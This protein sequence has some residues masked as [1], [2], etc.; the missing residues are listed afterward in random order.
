M[1]RALS[2]I[3]GAD[4]Q[5]AEHLAE[6]G[7]MVEQCLVSLVRQKQ[8]LR[9]EKAIQ[10]CMLSGGKRLRPVLTLVAAESLGVSVERALR[11]ACAIEMIHTASLVLDDL[12]CMDDAKMR[13][14]APACHLAFGEDIAILAAVT[15]I[16]EA[17]QVVAGSPTLVDAEKVQICSIISD[18]LGVHGLAAGQER[19]LRD[20][21]AC[22]DITEVKAMEHNKT[23]ALF[24]TCVRIAGV[25]GGLTDTAAASLWKFG[26][27]L[28]FAFQIFDDLLDRLGSVSSTG[29]DHKQDEG[30]ATFVTLMSLSEAEILALEELQKGLAALEEVGM[31]N[32]C[33]N[34]LIEALFEGYRAQLTGKTS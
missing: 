4:G 22:T 21:T 27:H 2:K 3:T 30:R 1:N 7:R 32:E 20:M 5:H 16:T 29:K 18:T 26:K 31:R 28:G 6:L 13:R 24:V 8:E 11:P 25:L 17:F 34:S 33:V 19:D 14:G 12:P 9:L 10:N 15:L 23:C